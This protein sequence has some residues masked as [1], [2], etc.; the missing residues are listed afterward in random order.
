M[1]VM[2][3]TNLCIMVCYEQVS[4][5]NATNGHHLLQLARTC[6]C[7]CCVFVCLCVCACACVLCVHTCVCVCWCILVYFFS[8]SFCDYNM[9]WNVV[10]FI[11]GAL[12]CPQLMTRYNICQI[13]LKVE[14]CRLFRWLPPEAWFYFYRIWHVIY[15]VM[16]NSWGLAFRQWKDAYV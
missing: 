15:R 7:V 11:S 6:V 3:V 13:Q 8:S 16:S 5:S 1:I 14:F 4:P 10:G 12:I 9:S 2:I